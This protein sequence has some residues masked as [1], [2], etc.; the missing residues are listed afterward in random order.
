VV[1]LGAGLVLSLA[2]LAVM[3]TSPATIRLPGSLLTAEIVR[4]LLAGR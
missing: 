4:K 1:A 2:A 3:V